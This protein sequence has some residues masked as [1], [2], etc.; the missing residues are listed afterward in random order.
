M[1]QKWGPVLCFERWGRV[2]VRGPSGR[3]RGQGTI[4]ENTESTGGKTA[5]MQL[6]FSKTLSRNV[7][8]EVSK[9]AAGPGGRRLPRCAAAGMQ[10]RRNP[11]CGGSGPKAQSAGPTRRPARVGMLPD[12][13][14]GGVLTAPKSALLLPEVLTA[15]KSALRSMTPRRA[16]P[17]RRWAAGASPQPHQGSE[18]AV[19]RV[20]VAT[21]GVRLGMRCTNQ[22]RRNQHTSTTACAVDSNGF[23]PGT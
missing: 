20:R 4:A 14:R 22:A 15:P 6:F 11:P 12:R 2:S 21:S 23:E 8:S 1:Q 17:A 3:P 10:L 18:V 19:G 16:A 7:D 9:L 13:S 5:E